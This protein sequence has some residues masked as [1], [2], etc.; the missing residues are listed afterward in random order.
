MREKLACRKAKLYDIEQ[1]PIEKNIKIRKSTPYRIPIAQMSP[2]SRY[3]KL[4]QESKHF[5]NIIKMICYRAETALANQLAPFYARSDD[6]I[7]SLIKALIYQTIDLF[8]DYERK[9]L[10]VTL[11]PLATQRDNRAI[12]EIIDRINDTNTIISRYKFNDEVQNHD[13]LICATSGVLTM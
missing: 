4:N 11:Y 7:R 3:C 6:D 5:Q 9:E 13:S 8:P 2:E 12:A 10:R 1:S